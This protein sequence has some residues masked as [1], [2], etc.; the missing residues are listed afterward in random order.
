MQAGADITIHQLS[1][2]YASHSGP[3]PALQTISTSIA[4]GEFVAIIGPSGCGKSTLLRAVGGL[5][6]PDSGQIRIG[7]QTAEQARRARTVG[8]V[9]QQAVLLPWHTAVQ[10]V[11]LPLRLFGWP[12]ARRQ[13]AAWHVLALV[14]LESFARAY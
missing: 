14:G 7:S 6:A 8:F 5:L 9:F 1:I 10:N 13:A 11:E 12:T 2:S 4:S 3:L